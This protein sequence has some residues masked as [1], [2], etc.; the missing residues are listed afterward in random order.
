MLRDQDIK[1]SV[2]IVAAPWRASSYYASAEQWTHLWW[3]DKSIFREMFEK[4]DLTSTLELACGH[5][6]HS[7][8]VANLTPSLSLMDILPENIEV[9]KQ[10]LAS[11]NN[12]RYYV[13]NG[14]DF[15]PLASCSLSSVFCYDAMVHF[16]PDIMASYLKD[17]VRVLTSG[18]MALFHHSNYGIY[19][20][21]HYG[22]NPHALN[23]MTIELFE[24]LASEAGISIV[25]TLKIDWGNVPD[26]D[27]VSL[28]QKKV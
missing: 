23:Y 26:L 10:R 17:T 28:L 15:N 22:L 5:G 27:R 25:E 6:R 9:C 12:V 1:K 16:S 19:S 21:E 24:N 18:G 3:S 7:E 14:F 2:E 20:E 4:L 11:R 13:N 8:I